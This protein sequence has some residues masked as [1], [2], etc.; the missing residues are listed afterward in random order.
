MLAS[1]REIDTR[2]RSNFNSLTA[3]EQ[4]RAMGRR[5]KAT[6]EADEV[7]DRRTKY[8]TPCA[9]LID[10][11]ERDAEAVRHRLRRQPGLREYFIGHLFVLVV[12]HSDSFVVTNENCPLRHQEILQDHVAASP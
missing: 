4:G 7:F 1:G 10:E 9:D 3:A 5:T 12:F 2:K 11:Y 6:D 8:C